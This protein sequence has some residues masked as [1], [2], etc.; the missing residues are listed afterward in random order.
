MAFEQIEMYQP[1]NYMVLNPKD[2]TSTHTYLADTKQLDELVVCRHVNWAH[3]NQWPT[4]IVSIVF[5]LVNRK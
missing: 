1:K 2:G 4:M 5:A 3:P